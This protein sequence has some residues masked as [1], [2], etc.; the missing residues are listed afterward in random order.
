MLI[1][2]YEFAQARKLNYINARTKDF[3]SARM[4]KGKVNTNSQIEKAAGKS[5]TKE[6]KTRFGKK[7][8]EIFLD[9]HRLKEFYKQ[10][11]KWKDFKKILLVK[12]VFSKKDI[13]ID[14]IFT[15]DLTLT[16]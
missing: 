6:E 4:Q 14:E 2:S 12:F 5:T 11:K 3:W 16:T 1:K 7:Y 9:M 8:I 15:V 13:K 10:D